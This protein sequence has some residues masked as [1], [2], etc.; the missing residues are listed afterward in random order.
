M[1]KIR[2]D[3]LLALR[4]LCESR[5][6]AK[7]VI[8]AGKVWIGSER[9]DKPGRML[10]MD[11]E[12]EVK[13]PS[14][15]VGRGGHKLA[16]FLEEFGVSVKNWDVLDLG[17]STG[18]FTDCLLQSGARS[19]TC[20]DV[21]KGQLHGK[22][23]VDERVQ[24]REGINVRH[25]EKGDLPHPVYDLVTM[26][27]SFISLRKT[28]ENAWKFVRVAGQLIAL[29]KPQFEATKKEADAG[30]G[31]IRDPQVHQR[32]VEEIKHFARERLNHSQLVG[33]MESPLRGAEE[34][35][36]AS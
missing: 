35:G 19:A 14:P 30:R 5:L 16:A 25:L 27:L 21:G 12:L 31:I 9:I 32:V 26:D 8:M 15:Y 20:V 29:V 23:R 2:I 33:F 36:R 4:G 17:S 22:L 34:I 13:N 28:L 11:A 10:P 3:E 7:A 1:K 6:K 18:G 24:V